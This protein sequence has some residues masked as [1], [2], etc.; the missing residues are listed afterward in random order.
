VEAVQLAD[1]CLM[2]FQH[3]ALELDYL[4]AADTNQ[5]AMMGTVGETLVSGV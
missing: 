5:V 2:L 4:P 1:L 3:R